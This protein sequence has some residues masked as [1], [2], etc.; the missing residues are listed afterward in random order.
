M[1][2]TFDVWVKNWG[3]AGFRIC[4]KI[5]EETD[6]NKL[7]TVKLEKGDLAV[8]GAACVRWCDVSHWL[9]TVGLKDNEVKEAKIT[10]K[11]N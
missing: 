7:R 1:E 3:D 9:E 4:S 8:D 2:K 6:S 11:I 5:I 10:L